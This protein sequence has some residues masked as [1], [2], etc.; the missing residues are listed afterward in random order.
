MNAIHCFD[1]DNESDSCMNLPLDSKQLRAF[2]TLVRLGSFTLAA[3]ELNLTQSAISHAMKA[4]EQDVG[5]RLLD[6]MGKKILPT[7]AGEQLLHHAEK[8]LKEMFATRESLQQLGKWGKGRL[9]IG[10]SDAACQYILPGV[11]REFKECFPQYGI[12]IEPGDVS[13]CIDA[14]R[15]NRIDLGLGL[16]PDKEH[17]FEFHPL[18]TDELAFLMSPLHPWAADG[19]ITRAEIPRQNYVLYNKKSYTFRM[20]EKYFRQEEVVLNTVIELGSMEAIKELVKLGLGVSILAPWIARKELEERSL[21]CLPLGRRKLRRNWGFFHWRSH[22]LG[23]AEETFLGIC[24]SAT[25][26]LSGWDWR[27][28]KP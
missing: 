11:L 8:I 1:D 13:E 3:K 26:G 24:R 28:S 7:Q 6:R 18:F 4:L 14:L 23:L 2:V 19:S 22:R 15:N 5:C 12:T 17:Q 9:R 10:T 25:E 21:V 27:S 16:E 20:V